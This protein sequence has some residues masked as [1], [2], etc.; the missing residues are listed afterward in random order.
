MSYSL[1]LQYLIF[2]FFF[3]DEIYN[4]LTEA[5]RKKLSSNTASQLPSGKSKAAKMRAVARG[6]NTAGSSS[7][8]EQEVQLSDI[9]YQNVTF[10]IRCNCNKPAHAITHFIS[11]IILLLCNYRLYYQ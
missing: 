10:N 11:L 6:E 8:S 5:P 9:Q 3:Q 7:K 1:L 4:E 2:P